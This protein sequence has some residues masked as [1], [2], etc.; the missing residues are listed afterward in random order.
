MKVQLANTYN[1]AK[2][3]KVD[4]W[5]ATP[6]FDGVRAVFI[7]HKGFF[8]RN[9]KPIIGFERMVEILDDVCTERGLLFIDGELILKGNSF[10]ASQS[11]ILS[12]EHPD[13]S[14][15]EFHVF[16]VGGDFIDTAHM[17][18]NIPDLPRKN[19]YRVISELIPNTFEAVETACRKFTEKGYEGVVLRDPYV[20]Y[21]NDRTDFLLKYKFFREADLRITHAYEGT[22]KFAG[23]LGSLSVEGEIDGVKVRSNVGT[24]LTAYDRMILFADKNLAGKIITVKYQ[25]LTDKPDSDGY[26]S[27]RFPAVIGLKEDRDFQPEPVKETPKF[28]GKS[29]CTFGK[30]GFVEAVF[31]IT[32]S[33][34][35][36]K[37]ARR[38]SYLP[39]ESQ[40]AEWKIL[41][42]ECKSIQEGIKLIA[43]LKLTIPKIM[44]F[45]KYLGVSLSGCKYL[46]AEIVRWLIEGSLGN[47]LKAERIKECCDKKNNRGGSEWITTHAMRSLLLKSFYAMPMS[48]LMRNLNIFRNFTACAKKRLRL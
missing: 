5:Y 23:T 30:Y 1:P 6:K 29:K 20:P 46:K 33:Q 2:K 10:Q 37:T 47:W 39:T 44:E 24:G 41:L 31:Q 32:N 4:F 26:Y 27:L 15:V 12:A 16:A 11:V 40:M 7:P 34:L 36:S 21:I 19:I 38:P 35:L 9:E 14:K 22:G 17:L 13:K 8:T 42:R 43:D 48:F 25:S 18:K 28:T 45:A 3:Y